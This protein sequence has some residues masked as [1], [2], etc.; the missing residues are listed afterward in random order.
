MFRQW[1]FENE[2]SLAAVIWQK[3]KARMPALSTIED[4][5]LEVEH[6]GQTYLIM[7]EWWGPG[8]VYDSLRRHKG[9]R[10]SEQAFVNKYDSW[11]DEQK[12][13]VFAWEVRRRLKSLQR[14][15][16]TLVG[17]GFDNSADTPEVYPGNDYCTPGYIVYLKQ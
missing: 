6:E 13:K 7:F 9:Y 16:L 10:G 12:Q 4:H 3:A 1:L 5:V 17:Y 11:D 2:M 8:C 15:G 14:P